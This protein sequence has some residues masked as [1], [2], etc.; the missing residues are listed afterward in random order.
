MT[1]GESARP[2]LAGAA[3]YSV[4]WQA[5]G[6]LA[7]HGFR[8][9]LAAVLAHRLSPA[10]YASVALVLVLLGLVPIVVESG[11][12]AAIVQ[13]PELSPRVVRVA[14][15]LSLAVG[16]FLGVSVLATAEL[17]ADWTGA[18]AATPFLRTASLLFP[19]ASV[20]TVAAA[21]LRR[22]LDF[23]SLFV[24]ET[25]SN[26]VGYVVVGL[27]LTLVYLSPW[28]LVASGAVQVA[29]FVGLVLLRAPHSIVPLSEPAVVKEL[30]WYSGGTLGAAALNFAAANADYLVV[31]G[32][33]GAGALS[34]YNRAFQLMSVPVSLT[35]AVVSSVAFS[36]MAR[37]QHD[38]P[39]LRAAYLR[40]VRLGAVVTFPVLAAM[41][42][43]AT[44]L[45][46]VVY[47]TQWG[48][49]I[50]PFV[51]LCLAGSL[52]CVTSLADALA[53]AVGAVYRQLWRQAL[54]AVAVVLLAF[55]GARFGPT[56][57]AAGVG[58]AIVVIY[59][60]NARLAMRLADVGPR[61][62]L[63]AHREGVVL[64]LVVALATGATRFAAERWLPGDLGALV[65]GTLGAVGVLWALGR[66]LL[67]ADVLADL[68]RIAARRSA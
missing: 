6:T 37:V 48:G 4:R 40:S 54:Y 8:F 29:A 30:T 45:V 35:S 23:R 59:L 57:A 17:L 64:A 66:R 63:V 51:V 25:L 43:M 11:V 62:F 28:A 34:L 12:G 50:R 42:A 65:A 24:A 26:L 32:V 61:D 21:L 31:G 15:T 46:R 22:R 47:G 58:A 3:A 27:P 14:F 16:S 18:P 33:L 56:G 39:R 13:R 36:A 7:R 55:V 5:A 19:L 49:S 41:A 52:R 1:L 60:L 10:S 9:V 68:R 20:G 44:P 53:R 38:T 67:P 2:S